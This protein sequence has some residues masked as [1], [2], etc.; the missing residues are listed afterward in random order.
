[1]IKRAD[2]GGLAIVST[3]PMLSLV[4]AVKFLVRRPSD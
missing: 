2:E 1:M 4:L 3:I